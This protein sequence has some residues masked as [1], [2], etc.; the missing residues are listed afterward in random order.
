VAVRFGAAVL[1]GAE[2]GAVGGT[3]AAG[4]AVSVAR[5]SVLNVAVAVGLVDAA[6]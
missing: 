4:D 1:V 3:V 6:R 5:I 2:V